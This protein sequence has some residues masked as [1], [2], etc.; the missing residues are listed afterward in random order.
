MRNP[1]LMIYM[2]MNRRIYKV[3][4]ASSTVAVWGFFNGATTQPENT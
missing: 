1:G 2:L 4:F 3:I